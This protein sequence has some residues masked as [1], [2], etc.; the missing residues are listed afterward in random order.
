MKGP[1]DVKGRA[2]RGRTLE[3][4][5]RNLAFSYSFGHLRLRMNSTGALHESMRST[6]DDE[7]VAVSSGSN[8]E[9]HG[10]SSGSRL[11]E[12]TSEMSRRT[13]SLLIARLTHSLV[14]VSV[15]ASHRR[16]YG[17]NHAEKSISSGS[18]RTTTTQSVGEGLSLVRD[19]DEERGDALGDERAVQVLEL[20]HAVVQLEEVL[21]ARCAFLLRRCG[22]EGEARVVQVLDEERGADR[23]KERGRVDLAVSEEG[24][25]VSAGAAARQGARREE[26]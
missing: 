21:V 15:P 6:I 3:R 2:T 7:C 20:A 10:V 5:V 25:E 16:T 19:A 14:C 26:E 18:L 13:L 23:E 4:P 17:S 1:S 11:K 22:V 8:C 12:D 9:G 24:R